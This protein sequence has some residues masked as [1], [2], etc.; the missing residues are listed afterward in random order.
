M[1]LFSER[2]N[3][4]IQP[5]HWSPAL[6]VLIVLR[7]PPVAT[8][9]PA[10]IGEDANG[11]VAVV[12]RSRVSVQRPSAGSWDVPAVEGRGVVVLHGELVVGAR[13]LSSSPHVCV[14]RGGDVMDEP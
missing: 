4:R 8:P 1:S 12:Q 5:A 14:N 9:A 10:V 11:R 2:S 13:L 6:E 3:T 7:S